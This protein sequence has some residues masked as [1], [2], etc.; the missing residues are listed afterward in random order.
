MQYQAPLGDIKFVLFDVLG[1]NRLTGT[2]VTA[3]D[4]RAGAALTLAGLVAEG[5]TI[6][7]DAWQINRGY[8]DF[9]LKALKL[10]SNIKEC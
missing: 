2:R 7:E 3:T 10:G 8:N 5:E 1:G 6:I 9:A 4:L